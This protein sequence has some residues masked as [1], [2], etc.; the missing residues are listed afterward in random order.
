MIRSCN[1]GDVGINNRQAL[2]GAF[3]NTS[4]G[5]RVMLVFGFLPR[6]SVLGVVK[7]D[8]PVTYDAARVHERSRIIV[9]AIDARRQRFPD[10]A[11]YLCQ[12]LADEPE[13]NRWSEAT[14]GALLRNYDCNNMVIYRRGTSSLSTL[15][16]RHGSA[17][18]EH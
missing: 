18:V 17:D 6:A 11:P 13:D 1:P 4:G 15:Q 16:R 8:P 10:E 5:M 9:L 14:R 3:A 12:S 7:G 2:H